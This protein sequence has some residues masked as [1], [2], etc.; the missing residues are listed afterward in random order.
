MGF[1]FFGKSRSIRVESLTRDGKRR[2]EGERE[3][4]RVRGKE[5]EREREG[6]KGRWEEKKRGGVIKI[7][8]RK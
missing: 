4:K 1:S 3:R 6:E 2:A 8:K 5:R 7:Q